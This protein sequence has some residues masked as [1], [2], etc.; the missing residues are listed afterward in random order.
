[1][2]R[3][4]LNKKAIGKESLQAGNSL[5][6]TFRMHDPRV[7][8]F[9]ATDPLENK[10]PFFS[11]YQFSANTPLMA[12]ELEGLESSNDPNPNQK[13]KDNGSLWNQFSA[14]PET[15]LMGFLEGILNKFNE[16]PTKLSMFSTPQEMNEYL[17]RDINTI[18]TIAKL[19]GFNAMVDVL[20]TNDILSYPKNAFM[21]NINVHKEIYNG[22]SSDLSLWSDNLTSGDLYKTSFTTGQF[23]INAAEFAIPGGE[24]ELE[25]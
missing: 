25:S 17:E 8:R 11:P 5:N 21:D 19:Q 2:Q 3:G 12:V 4:S 9:F 6:Y 7:G 18:K 23:T 24:K 22:F 20:K 14:N 16:G 10:Y 15:A 13:P 1:M